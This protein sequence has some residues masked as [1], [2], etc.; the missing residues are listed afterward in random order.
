MQVPF[1]SIFEYLTLIET[2]LKIT[3]TKQR[4]KALA[5]SRRDRGEEGRHAAYVQL[6]KMKNGSCSKI[7]MLNLRVNNK[8]VGLLGDVPPA[9]SD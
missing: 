1:K 9:S 3:A 8:A 7:G 6:S 5:G 4:F 2:V